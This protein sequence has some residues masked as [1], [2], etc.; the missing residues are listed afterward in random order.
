[1]KQGQFFIAS[2]VL[3]GVAISLTTLN[4][5]IPEEISIDQSRINDETINNA[6]FVKRTLNE[7]SNF[8]RIN[9]LMPYTRRTKIIVKNDFKIKDHTVEAIINLPNNAY[10]DSLTLVDENGKKVPFNIEWSYLPNKEGLLFF[11]ASANARENKKYYLYYTILGDDLKQELKDQLIEYGEQG[12]DVWVKTN[13]YY[14]KVDTTKGGRIELINSIGSSDYLNYFDNFIT[15]GSNE[16]PLSEAS[17]VQSII[18]N[19]GYYLKIEFNGTR[20]T[21]ETFNI[22]EL[23]FPDQIW[24]IDEMR[25]A[26]ESDC[27]WSARVIVD[28]TKLMNYVDSNGSTFEPTSEGGYEYIS[29]SYWFELYDDNHGLGVAVDNQSPIY[30]SSSVAENRAELRFDNEGNPLEGLYVLNVTLIP[31]QK[32]GLNKTKQNHKPSTIVIN[33]I[34]D[35]ELDNLFE[36]FDDYFYDINAIVTHNEEVGVFQ[37]NFRNSSDW[38]G[39]YS[40][41]TTFT[42]NGPN[43]KTPIEASLFFN[44]GVDPNSILLYDVGVKQVQVSTDNYHKPSY[45]NYLNNSLVNNTLL[46]FNPNGQDFNIS[47]IKQ[48]SNDLSA[49]LYYPNGSLMSYYNVNTSPYDISLIVNQSGFYNLTFNGSE[50]FNINS[51]LPKMIATIPVGLAN[52][53]PLYF[54]GTESLND[55]NLELTTYSSTVQEFIVYDPWNNTISNNS[56]STE[57]T[58]VINNPTNPCID[59]CYY[60][61]DVNNPER[62]SISSTDLKYVSTSKDYL[63]NPDKP[64]LIIISVNKPDEFKIYYDN[65][66]YVN[67]QNYTSDLNYSEESFIVSNSLFSFDVNDIKFYYK[68]VEWF[69]NRGWTTC[70]NTCVNS[71]SNVKFVEKGSERVVVWANTSVGVEYYFH[72][73]PSIPYF[74]VI[75][76]ASGNHTFGPNWRINNTDDTLYSLRSGQNLLGNSDKLVNYYNLTGPE[77][78]VT[79]SD[80]VCKASIIFNTN[81]LEGVNSIKLNDTST[82]FTAFLPGTYAFIINENPSEYLKPL[83]IDQYA[84][85]INYDYKTSNLEM[86]GQLFG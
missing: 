48:E 69:G 56:R 55:L 30:L 7:V 73:Y 15:C 44:Q 85:K 64:E 45:F 68:G 65:N 47:I 11:Q 57:G 27:N 43:I 19:M 86:G 52:A 71:F 36:L 22:I 10:V 76:S 2:V 60:R 1:M 79:K 18:T 32:A 49:Y 41:R 20:F 5:Y 26:D 38:Y 16:S 61:L 83:R 35:T 24:I 25:I 13:N 46:L 12:N 53:S 39:N 75:T 77:D 28:K 80:D 17:N 31:L 4:L 34:F 14:A 72:F 21:N 40:F 8:F 9:W 70:T 37:E 33:E 3:I 6:L 74:K 67:N 51:S 82:H 63:I 58:T 81:V 62:Y 59:N 50:S 84:V 54:L 29:D 23:F 78:Y 66:T 42:M